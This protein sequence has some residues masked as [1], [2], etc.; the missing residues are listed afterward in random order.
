[1]N[2]CTLLVGMWKN[3]VALENNLAIPQ[4]VKPRIMIWCK[5]SS[6]TYVPEELKTGTQ[7]NPCTWIFIVV[8]T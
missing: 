2:A 7:T 3:A 5:Y 1:M 4:T 6:Y 8:L